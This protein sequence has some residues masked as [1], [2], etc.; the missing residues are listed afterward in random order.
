[1]DFTVGFVLRNLVTQKKFV[2]FRDSRI[3]FNDFRGNVRLVT[4]RE[5]IY[6]RILGVSK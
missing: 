6:M 4:H 5:E 2:K 1:M 3:F